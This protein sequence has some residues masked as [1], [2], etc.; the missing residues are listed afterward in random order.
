MLI[1]TY[2]DA[3]SDSRKINDVYNNILVFLSIALTSRRNG[4][5]P[6]RQ[7]PKIVINPYN[8]SNILPRHIPAVKSMKANI[9]LNKTFAANLIFLSLF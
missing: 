2:P 4:E 8:G 3:M 6:R 1:N 9:G 5:N 7:P